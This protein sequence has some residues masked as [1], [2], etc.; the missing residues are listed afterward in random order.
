M[1]YY[2]YLVYI[3]NFTIKFIMPY[4][5]K[6]KSGRTIIHLEKD[7]QHYYYGSIAAIY[8]DFTKEDI[9][10]SYGSLRNYGLSPSKPF[11]NKY[12]TIRKGTLKTTPKKIYKIGSIHDL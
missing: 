8:N 7:N 5:E 12:S 2:E 10:V 3:H 9:G 1:T 4:M 6:N 11:K